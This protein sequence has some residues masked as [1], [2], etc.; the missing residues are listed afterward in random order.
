MLKGIFGY[1]NIAERLMR[2]DFHFDWK[3]KHILSNQCKKKSEK[4][5][6]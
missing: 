5:E 2:R 4:L 6:Y 1:C 3:K